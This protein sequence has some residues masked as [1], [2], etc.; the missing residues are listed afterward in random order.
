LYICVIDAT[1]MKHFTLLLI[2]MSCLCC[3][4]LG[5]TI[6]STNQTIEK[7]IVE[8]NTTIINTAQITINDSLIVYGT[9]VNNGIIRTKNA[10]VAGGT[11]C[12]QKKDSILIEQDL[13]LANSFI[14]STDSINSVNITASNIYINGYT[15][16]ESAYLTTQFL[17]VN[18]TLEFTGKIGVKT[19]LEDFIINGYFKN[20]DNENI[21]LYGN[22]INNSTSLCKNANFELHGI[23]KH[24]YGDF[25][26]YRI[27]LEKTTSTYTNHGNLTVTNSFS[28]KGTLTQGENSFLD[29]K[30]TT[31]P[32][33]IANAIGNT[34]SYT[35]GGNQ[36]IHCDEFYNLIVSKDRFASII[37]S[38]NTQI[39][40]NLQ[41]EKKAFVD[42]NGFELIILNPYDI[43][44][45][46]V[47]PTE[48]NGI[49]L[50]NGKVIVDISPNQTSLIPLLTNDTAIATLTIQNIETEKQ[51]FTIDSLFA[52]TTNNGHSNDDFIEQEFIQ[53]TWHIQSNADKA[54]IRCYW[55]TKSELPFFNSDSSTIF[56]STGNGWKRL[57]TSA[58]E[59]TTI[60]NPNGYYTI[61]N[62]LSFLGISMYDLYFQKQENLIKIQWKSTE[63]KT[64]LIEKSYDGKHFFS[65]GEFSEKSNECID[66]YSQQNIVYYRFA[67]KD[68]TGAIE[69]SQIYTIAHNKSPNIH[70]DRNNQTISYNSTTNYKL[71]LYDSKGF[72][73]KQN[74]NTIISLSDIPSGIYFITIETPTHKFTQKF[75]W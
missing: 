42:C 47:I 63:N 29:I 17:I 20:T 8:E 64:I 46:E 70:I 43:A 52:F 48:N 34:V 12:S 14:T 66:T 72:I 7:L 69:Y 49:F 26:C 56:K 62:N 18:D 23:D 16:V 53:T 41:I 54:K 5:Q 67:E 71:T 50:N 4:I 58:K 38:K 36:T 28:G 32:L 51:T 65:I 2:F 74:S 44:D 15:I 73:R 25:S 30:T 59:Q 6:F 1:Q 55:S 21:V 31:S 39:L 60:H 27:D 19:V 22:A 57:S 37:L 11:V 75:L 33:I 68:N 40:N 10:L 9:L 3:A 35:R 24:F 45:S 13:I 61:G